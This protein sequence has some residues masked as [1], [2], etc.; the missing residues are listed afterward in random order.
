MKQIVDVVKGS[1]W[2][3]LI[4][5]K[6]PGQYVFR[7]KSTKK[8][9][10]V[11]TVCGP[12]KTDQSFK[13]SCDVNFQLRRAHERGLLRHAKKFEGEYDD[14]P[15]FDFQQAQFQIA[16]AKTMFEQ[17]PSNFRSR[18]EN[19]PAKF[20]KWANDPASVEEMR[21]LGILKGVD[22][23]R[24]DGTPSD[25]PSGDEPPAPAPAPAPAPG[26]PA[27]APPAAGD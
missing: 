3:K 20:L 8:V 18:F 10:K 27:A 13:D 11:V 5:R 15:D 17:L 24:A 22:G 2:F 16:R 19:D 26:G 23:R 7:D 4:D 12:T 14:F 25:M 1:D 21:S 6:R 9:L